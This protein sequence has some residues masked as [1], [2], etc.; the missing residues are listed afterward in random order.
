[1]SCRIATVGCEVLNQWA[2]RDMSRGRMPACNAIN[3][4]HGSDANENV[5]RNPN[6]VAASTSAER[7]PTVGEVG[8]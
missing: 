4:D 1:M 2:R 8:V 7:K 3:V 5:C 6:L